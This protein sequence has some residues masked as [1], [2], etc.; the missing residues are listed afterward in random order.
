MVRSRN[1]GKIFWMQV[2]AG[3]VNTAVFNDATNHVPGGYTATVTLASA[4]PPSAASR[5]RRRPQGLAVRRPHRVPARPRH[6]PAAGHLRGQP[7][8]LA[9]RP[10][11][12]RQLPHPVGHQGA[13]PGQDPADELKIAGNCNSCHESAR[14]QGHDPRPGPPQQDPRQ[15]RHRSVRR[16][17]R[18]PAAGPAL[19]A[20]RRVLWRQLDS[21]WTGGKPISKRIHAIHDGA[22][23]LHP[24]ATVDHADGVPTAATGT[25]SSRRTS[26]T[27]RPATSTARPAAPGRPTRTGWRA[28]AAT[29]ATRRHPHDADDVRPDPDDAMERR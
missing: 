11:Q 15:H 6:R 26:A 25:S 10:G 27:A 20:R 2:G 18:L 22:N 21:G 14:R 9:G 3:A 8:D 29:T 7:G 17:P 5:P 28:A 1:I 12:R 23:L 24:V 13:V 19:R 4:R 16:L